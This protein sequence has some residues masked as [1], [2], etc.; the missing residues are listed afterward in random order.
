MPVHCCLQ[1]PSHQYPV[2]S[3]TFYLKKTTHFPSPQHFT[4]PPPSLGQPT[5]RSLPPCQA[6]GDRS[7]PLFIPA[8]LLP[9]MLSRYDK[10]SSKF[11]SYKGL[12]IS[13]IKEQPFGK[14]LQG[15]E[16]S[17]HRQDALV[18]A[19]PGLLSDPGG[20]EGQ[21][22]ALGHSKAIIP[23]VI[24]VRSCRIRLRHWE[25]LSKTGLLL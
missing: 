13:C 16:V 11:A 17:V 5:A 1:L 15:P 4:L 22:P 2:S 25:R 23:S 20:R 9:G 21:K 8:P 6:R 7:S 18:L 10:H 3:K 12:D 14:G 19:F 24:E